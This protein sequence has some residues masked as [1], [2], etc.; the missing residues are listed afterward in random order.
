MADHMSEIFASDRRALH[1][2]ALAG[3]DSLRISP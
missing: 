3:G 1:F 2:I